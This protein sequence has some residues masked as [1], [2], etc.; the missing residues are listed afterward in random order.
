TAEPNGYCGGWER[1][2]RAGSGRISGCTGISAARGDGDRSRVRGRPLVYDAE[3]GRSAAAHG[4]ARPVR[5]LTSAT[6]RRRPTTLSQLLALGSRLDGAL[7]HQREDRAEWG[8]WHLPAR[9]RP[10]GRC[11][12]RQLA[13]RKLRSAV[14]RAAGGAAQRGHRGD[15]CAGDAAR[16]G[17]DAVNAAAL[18]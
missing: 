15:A 17:G 9:A 11:P 18:L 4:S 1:G 16:A 14:R 8:R 5:G 6:E 13:A 10:G 12:R 3:R 7:S 2:P